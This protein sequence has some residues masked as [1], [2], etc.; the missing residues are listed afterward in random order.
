MG[1]SPPNTLSVFWQP[2]VSDPAV[3]SGLPGISGGVGVG[4]GTSNGAVVTGYQVLKDSGEVLATI[5]DPTAD[6][7]ILTVSSLRGGFHLHV[8]RTFAL[9]NP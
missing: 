6:R 8:L 7:A 1:S 2:V 5:P 3:A 9:L 4:V